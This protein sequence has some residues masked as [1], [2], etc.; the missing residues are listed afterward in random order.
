MRSQ[1]VGDLKVRRVSRCSG[2]TPRRLMIDETLGN[3]SHLR[4]GPVH[5]ETTCIG[6][7]GG[8]TATALRCRGSRTRVGR[9]E[10]AARLSRSSSLKQGSAMSISVAV[11]LPRHQYSANRPYPAGR[12]YA[13]SPSAL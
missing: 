12:G 5:L 3:A 4:S 11:G 7:D 2:S 8:C 1:P 10:K 9:P 13:H 6:F